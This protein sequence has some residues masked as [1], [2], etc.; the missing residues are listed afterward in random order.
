MRCTILPKL[1]KKLKS[2]TSEDGIK[3][4]KRASR[5][6]LQVY[7]PNLHVKKEKLDDTSTMNTSIDVEATQPDMST[8]TDAENCYNLVAK[9]KMYFN[10]DETAVLTKQNFDL[11]LSPDNTA[12]ELNSASSS[13]LLQEPA[14]IT[15]FHPPMPVL[16][17]TLNVACTTK[18]LV[19]LED[20]T[21]E[22]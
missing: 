15:T 19:A 16:C 20:K 21:N 5:N 1:R 7:D 4:R 3:K 13:L 9:I 2:D 11:L 8:I 12:S 6:T 14:T 17:N 18:A 22:E 10:S